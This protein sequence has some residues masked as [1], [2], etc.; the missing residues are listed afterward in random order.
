MTY[1]EFINNIIETRGRTM[2]VDEKERHH[3]LPKCLGGSNDPNNL[4]DLTL[5][6]HFIAHKLLT[7]ENPESKPL[8][9]AFRRMSNIRRVG[10]TRTIETPEEYREARLENKRQTVKTHYGQELREETKRKIS[11]SN[12][13]K[14]RTKEMNEANRQ[15]QLEYLKTHEN[16]YKGR[17]HSAEARAK[18]SK[19]HEGRDYSYLRK[20]IPPEEKERRIKKFR[21]TYFSKSDEE[22]SEIVAKRLANRKQTKYWQGKTLPDEI[23]KKI[24]ETLKRKHLCSAVAIG[25]YCEETGKMYRSLTEAEKAT[26]VD[27]HII[28]KYINGKMKNSKWHFRETKITGAEELE[29]AT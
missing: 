26:G 8:A 7:E 15:R 5:E 1:S 18:M 28:R 13:G 4:I 6:E 3:V 21:E 12:T 9:Y 27:R 2:D 16:P 20:P 24:S 17:K 22:R 23:R 25:V 29:V 19:A 10:L 14:K 11:A